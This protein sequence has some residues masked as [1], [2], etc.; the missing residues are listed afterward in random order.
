MTPALAVR[1]LTVRFGGVVPVDDLSLAVGAGERVA[2]IGPNGA[3]KSTVL[4]AVSGFV[5]YEGSVSVGGAAVD[6]LRPHQRVA[7]GLVRTFQSLDLFE[8]LTVHDNVACG[9]RHRDAVS[10]SIE[11]FGLASVA[12]TPAAALPQS[13]RRLVAL[14]RAVAAAPG[15]LLTDEPAAGMDGHERSALAAHLVALGSSGTAV[16]VVDHD[17]GFV[18]EVCDRV[19]VLD[20]GVV[21]A[22]GTPQEVR[23]D[24][25]VVAAYLGGS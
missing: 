12:S 15:V 19:I 22:T 7:R 20:A 18:S 8:D 24:P 17:L 5:P 21:V 13:T 11:T 3:G 16:L 1:G 25:C 14:A 9:G 6:G 2:L 23:R 4:D 10:S